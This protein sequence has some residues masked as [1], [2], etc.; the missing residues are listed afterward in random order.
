MAN[1]PKTRRERSPNAKNSPE[2][3]NS[4]FSLFFRFPL[5]LFA[6]LFHHWETAVQKAGQGHI[7]SPFSLLAHSCRNKDLTIGSNPL[8]ASPSSLEFFSSLSILGWPQ[9]LIR[10]TSWLH[11]G[12]VSFG[13]KCMARRRRW[14]YEAAIFPSGGPL[15]REGLFNAPERVCFETRPNLF[16]VRP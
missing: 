5:I 8:S 7:F 12:V 9:A 15:I 13:A 2:A 16:G 10:V 1:V 14:V 11:L 3:T 4:P 6:P